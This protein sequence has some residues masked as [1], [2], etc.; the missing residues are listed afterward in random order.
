MVL[1]NKKAQDMSIGTLI[2][3]VLGI[4]VLVLLILGFSIGWGNLWE[5]IN[6]FGG[7]SSIGDV[8]TACNL[9]VTSNNPYD[10]CQNFKKVK[11]NGETQY[12]NC[13][14]IEDQL[15]SKIT[16]CA[17]D[18]NNKQQSAK[19]YCI[20]L[21]AGNKV[22]TDKPIK[23]NDIRCPN[24]FPDIS[25]KKSCSQIASESKW[26]NP[27]EVDKGTICPQGTQKIGDDKYIYSNNKECCAT[28]NNNN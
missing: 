19:T 8:V 1:K 22:T 28:N 26:T 3:I 7:S 21:I 14:F 25:N 4:I 9:A 16:S 15:D 24:D 27:S 2:L 10:Y 11:V 23:V 18:Y 17:P 13:Q 5:K 20:I 12:V 6:I